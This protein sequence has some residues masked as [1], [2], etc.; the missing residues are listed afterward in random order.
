MLWFSG[1]AS[2]A[3]LLGAAVAALKKGNN[4]TLPLLLAGLACLGLFIGGA[5]LEMLGDSFLAGLSGK[6]V[7]LEATVSEIP[8]TRGAKETFVANATMARWAGREI[9]ISEDVLVDLYCY[10]KCDSPA[11]GQFEEGTR[12]RM[13]GT[14]G[15][16]PSSPGA[17]FDYGRYLRRRGV[18][19]VITTTPDHLSIFPG[20][21]GGAAGLV[22]SIRHHARE[23]LDTGDWGAAGSLLKGMVLGDDRQVPADVIDDFRDSGLLHMLAVSGQ[24]VVLLGLVV[25]FICRILL[26]PRL[27]A[28][29]AAAVVIGIY[30]PLTGAGPSIVRAGIVGVLGLAALVLSR[31]NSPYH[32]LALAAAAILTINPYSLLDPGFQLSFGAVLAIFLVAPLISAPLGFLPPLLKEAVAISTAAGLVTAPITLVHFHQV[33]L[34]TVPANVAAAPVAGIIMLLGTLSVMAAPVLPGLNWLLNAAASLCTGYLIHIARFFSSLPGA[35]YTGGYIE[36]VAIIL[37]YGML[38]GMIIMGRFFGHA[39]VM[40]WLKRRRY[41]A[42]A[43][44]MALAALAGFSCLGAGAAGTPPSAFTVSVLDVGQ[45]DAVLIQDP[46]GAT[47]L[48]DGGPG[49]EVLDRLAESG[50][51]RLDA[52]ILSHPHADHLAG[53]APVLN[54]YP[55]DGVYDAATQSSSPLYR[56][57]LKL[58]EGKGIPY[59]VLRQGREVKFG[60]LTLSV[61]SP[62]DNQRGDMNANSVVLVASY[63]GLDILCPG[64]AEGDIL[65]ALDIP[66]VEVYKVGHHGSKDSLL[67]PLLDRIRPQVAVVSVGEGNSYGHPADDTLSR[68]K[69]SGAA[70]YRT[71]RQGTVRISLTDA[72]MEVRSE[73]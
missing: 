55:V 8:K 24:N 19:S 11:E 39:A 40:S 47:V 5:R 45:G 15:D 32:F 30:V 43:T 21:R 26:V 10:D 34:V 42:A 22:D 64:D 1:L 17:D 9:E 62:T 54:K 73:R 2:A 66:P 14:V 60:E 69:A 25:L 16:P 72:G 3:L 58:V 29:V 61:Y 37:F 70:V 56:D 36:A 52:V 33:S 35:V 48:I 31:Q 13:E 71:D 49:S 53:L 20:G 6:W 12:V 38:T 28:A 18:N 68:L 57:F 59:S 63:R 65:T 51:A 4:R 41:L 44:V 50:V 27:A 7:T 23:S 67:K 46:G